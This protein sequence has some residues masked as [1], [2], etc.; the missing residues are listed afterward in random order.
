MLGYSE[1]KIKEILKTSLTDIER[2]KYEKAIY[3]SYL[4]DNKV[5]TYSI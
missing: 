4:T 3:N 2:Y 5:Y 1:Q